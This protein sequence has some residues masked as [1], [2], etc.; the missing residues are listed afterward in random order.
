MSRT[1]TPKVV[2]KAMEPEDGWKPP[3][4]VPARFKQYLNQRLRTRQNRETRLLGEARSIR[5]RNAAYLW[6]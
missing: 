5:K 4:G 2:T 6:W 1:R 3:V